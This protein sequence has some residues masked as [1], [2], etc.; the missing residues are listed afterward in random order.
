[1]K[2]YA[3]V[4]AVIVFIL[5]SI[6][7]FLYLTLSTGKLHLKDTGYNIYVIFDDVSGLQKN[8]PVMLNGLEVGRVIELAVYNK[9]NQSK[10]KLKLLI[11]KGVAIQE[12]P[13][14]SIKTLGLMGEKFIHIKSSEETG[15]IKSETVLIGKSPA[16][17]DALFNEAVSLSKDASKLIEEVKLLAKNLNET[18]EENQD[19]LNNIVSNFEGTS[20]NLEEFSLDLKNH[21]WKLFFRQKDKK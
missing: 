15:T 5:I 10:I 21:P 6:I 3:N 16:D 13:E 14:I 18:L 11:N 7:G 12:N 8:S 1:M 19:N 9:D 17:M 4:I 20:K 2:K